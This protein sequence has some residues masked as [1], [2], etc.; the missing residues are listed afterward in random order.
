MWLC[1]RLSPPYLLNVAVVAEVYFVV[2]KLRRA[3]LDSIGHNDE[4]HL[5]ELDQVSK[6]C[7]PVAVVIQQQGDAHLPFLPKRQISLYMY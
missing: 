5:P 4:L 6:G 2:D 1:L 3:T 7:A